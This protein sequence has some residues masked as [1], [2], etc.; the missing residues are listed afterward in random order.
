LAQGDCGTTPYTV[1]FN[2]LGACISP[3]TNYTVSGTNNSATNQVSCGIDDNEASWIAVT[4]PPD[5]TSMTLNWNDWN[6]CSGFLCYTDLTMSVFSNCSGTVVPGADCIDVSSGALNTTNL[7][8]YTVNGL[9]GGATYYIRISEEDNQNGQ[10][11]G[12][13]INANETISSTATCAN[14]TP[15]CS[16]ACVNF[17]AAESGTSAQ[18]GNDYDCLFTTPDPAWFYVQVGTPGSINLSLTAGSDIDFAMWGPY[19]DLAA[20]Q[21]ACGSYPLPIDCSFD[22]S[23]TETANI[24]ASATVGQVY[25]IV[26]T[27]YE[28]VSQYISVAQTGGT[29]GTDCT[30][31]LPCAISAI[32]VSLAACDD[33]GT[34]SVAADDFNTWTVTVNYTDA[35]STGTLAVSVIGST[36]FSGTTSVATTALASATS[37]T[38][39]FNVD[40]DATNVTLNAQFS[41]ATNC[42]FSLANLNGSGACVAVCNATITPITATQSVCSGDAADFNAAL[43][44][45]T[46]T[47]GVLGDFN[48]EWYE[49]VGFTIPQGA[50]STT[51]NGCNSFDIIY[52]LKAICVA[53]LSVQNG[54]TLTLSV[55]P[56]QP[57]VVSTDGDCT[58]PQAAEVD[59]VAAN[60]T[61]C[62]NAYATALPPDGFPCAATG[63]ESAPLTGT[64]TA[65]Q[66][67]TATGGDAT[68]YTPLD[69]DVPNECPF[70]LCPP[71]NI[72]I[73]STCAGACN[74]N[75]TTGNA[76]DDTYSINIT[77]A[78]EGKPN[79]GN[80]VLSLDG[81][82]NTTVAIAA[83]TG[84]YYHSFT[85]NVPANAA[86][87]PISVAFSADATCTT[88]AVLPAVA[89]CSPPACT[90]NNGT[91]GN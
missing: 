86:T 11:E 5:A 57:S 77:V 54:G 1:N 19:A 42:N 8:P 16:G 62:Q 73:V 9:T 50:T 24:P 89:S 47:T 25:V 33:A 49:N 34:P 12:M 51:N 60:G 39:T 35:P 38:F 63:L 74:N 87:H 45:A 21:A 4:L 78:F 69:Y 2:T 28:G 82:A 10:I 37:H 65:A 53:D 75:G 84:P 55:S 85:I 58:I 18:V 7:S 59:L 61:I 64:I 79:S 44:T 6:G 68:C 40:A 90:P 15:I 46:F 36:I 20:A 29:G 3:A 70:N 56:S 67:A 72:S 26:I 31:L 30:I 27:N 43:A 88:N 81:S 14:P 91:F 71:C 83:L 66:I 22:P 76:S 41:D 48:Y 23:N 13:T 52:Y 32:D 17:L 80:L